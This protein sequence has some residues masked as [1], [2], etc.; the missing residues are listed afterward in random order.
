MFSVC[1]KCQSGKIPILFTR[2]L[3]MKDKKP[4][5]PFSLT[6]L[7]GEIAAGETPTENIQ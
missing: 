6:T 5:V 2:A 1:D 3:D 4:L 7:N